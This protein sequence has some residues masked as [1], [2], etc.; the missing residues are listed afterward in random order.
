[1]PKVADNIDLEDA[2]V[3][4]RKEQRSM[5]GPTLIF[6]IKQFTD[7]TLLGF[8]TCSPW[9]RVQDQD[10]G[11]ATVN[12]KTG[13]IRSRMQTYNFGPTRGDYKKWLKKRKELH[14]NTKRTF[15]DYPGGP[16]I[17]RMGE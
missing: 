4:I 17:W 11:W 9:G 10:R 8:W 1:M 15:R 5:V 6:L 2:T 14:G 3:S 16:Y 7:G 13:L 12:I